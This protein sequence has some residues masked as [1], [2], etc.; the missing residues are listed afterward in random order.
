MQLKP[1]KS[2]TLLQPGHGES[3][4]SLVRQLLQTFHS[5]F[6]S[7]SIALELDLDP[8]ESAVE[9][10]L[11]HSAVNSLL[12]NA[13]E[14]MPNG[15]ELSVTLI[16]GSHQWELEIADSQ[17]MAFNTYDDSETKQSAD[18]PVVL[19]SPETERLRNAH[20]AAMAHGGNIQTWN[21]P[22]GGTA[23]VLVVPKH[24]SRIIKTKP[25]DTKMD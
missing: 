20:R 8:I 22:Q 19:P 3:V 10:Q 14:S 17:G 23:Q 18:L 1:V 5:Q 7:Q 21:C 25:A 2:T 24:R 16:D 4:E 6:E 15:G 12:E 11:I 9:P 13:I